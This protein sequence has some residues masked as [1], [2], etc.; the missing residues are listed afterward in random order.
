MSEPTSFFI[1]FYLLEG[2]PRSVSFIFF[3]RVGNAALTKGLSSIHFV[4]AFDVR[5][6]LVRSQ[7][8]VQPID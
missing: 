8:A 3:G 6:L 2:G 7:S 5:A 4:A 1:D